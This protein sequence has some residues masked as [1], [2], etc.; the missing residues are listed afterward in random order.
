LKAVV[1]RV[2]EASV[3]VDGQRI[4]D[5]PRGLLILLGVHQSDAVQDATALAQKIAGL[6][7]FPGDDGKLDRS[8]TGIDGE[9][10]VVSQ[11]TLI[12]DTR[13]GRRPSFIEAARPD[14]AVPLIDCFCEALVSAGVPTSTGKFGADMA[15]HLV[16]DG[17]L[18]ILLDTRQR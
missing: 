15:V 18:T 7:I 6:R 8:V 16:N 2:S 1:Q 9:A 13:R 10:L 4:A 5:I 14:Q 12:A 11:F 17:P 3:S